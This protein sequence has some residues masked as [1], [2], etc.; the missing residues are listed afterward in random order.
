MIRVKAGKTARAEQLAVLHCHRV[1]QKAPA[2]LYPRAQVVSFPGVRKE[3]LRRCA[4]LEK[5]PAAVGLSHLE[6]EGDLQ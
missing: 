3:G 2:A 6:A 4:A 1:A 5:Q